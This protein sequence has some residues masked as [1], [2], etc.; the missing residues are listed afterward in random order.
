MVEL[1]SASVVDFSQFSRVGN[2]SGRLFS[3]LIFRLHCFSLMTHDSWAAAL[4]NSSLRILF[5][6]ELFKS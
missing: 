1:G 4:A 2:C 3:R 6:E 5:G